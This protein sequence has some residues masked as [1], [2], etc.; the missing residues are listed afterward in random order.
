MT[1]SRTPPEPIDLGLDANSTSGAIEEAG[2]IDPELQ[3]N[4]LTEWVWVD[5][6]VSADGEDQ[7]ASG[8][9]LSVV[10]LGRLFWTTNQH[11]AVERVI[12]STPLLMFHEPYFARTRHSVYALAGP[13]VRITLPPQSLLDRSEE[14]LLQNIHAAVANGH[15]VEIPEKE[16]PS[17][18]EVLLSKFIF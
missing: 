11:L 10:L 5:L 3:V 1:Q 6:D 18:D 16:E 13:G 8:G 7:M 12:R 17:I 4:L 14:A 2:N 9:T 15:P